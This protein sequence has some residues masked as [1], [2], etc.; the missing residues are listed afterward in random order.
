M[1]SWSFFVLSPGSSYPLLPSRFFSTFLSQSMT[2]RLFCTKSPPRGI[3]LSFLVTSFMFDWKHHHSRDNNA[4]LLHT[5]V[6]A[7]VSRYFVFLLLPSHT[8]NTYMLRWSSLGNNVGSSCL[9][10]PTLSW[11]VWQEISHEY[12]DLAKS[13]SPHIAHLRPPRRFKGYIKMSPF[14]GHMRFS[15]RG[16]CCGIFS[17]RYRVLHPILRI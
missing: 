12:L 1:C 11:H 4:Q 2:S 17:W 3:L 6:C 10:F 15:V 5:Y 14:F 16:W 13:A 7:L 9:D 8:I